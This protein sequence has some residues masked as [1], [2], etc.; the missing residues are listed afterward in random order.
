M[1]SSI[2]LTIHRWPSLFQ[3]AASLTRQVSGP[4]RDQY[5]LM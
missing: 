1:S 4:K 5:V 3:I 2:R